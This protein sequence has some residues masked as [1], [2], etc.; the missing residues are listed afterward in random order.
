MS[1]STKRHRELTKFGA[2]GGARMGRMHH[3]PG[4]AEPGRFVL[5]PADGW[6]G[7]GHG[8]GR[9]AHFDGVS[10]AHV[11]LTAALAC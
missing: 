9:S 6:P 3:N 7:G 1:L 8:C 2:A 4:S 5:G 11:A 10:R